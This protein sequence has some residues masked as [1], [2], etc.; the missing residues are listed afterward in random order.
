M[1]PPGPLDAV[2]PRAE[3]DGVGDGSTG[4]DLLIFNF[5]PEVDVV[6]CVGGDATDLSRPALSAS[7]VEPKAQKSYMDSPSSSESSGRFFFFFRPA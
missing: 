4:L 3:V 5:N 7:L 2:G 1:D 6:W